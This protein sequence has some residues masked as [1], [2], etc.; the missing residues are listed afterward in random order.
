MSYSVH[1]E[2]SEEEKISLSSGIYKQSPLGFRIGPSPR[3]VRTNIKIT[4]SSNSNW[5]SLNEQLS[6]N[7]RVLS[8][9]TIKL[10]NMIEKYSIF[11]THSYLPAIDS[12][13]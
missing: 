10:N 13:E 9:S 2:D 1:D 8:H 4:S 5:Q 12:G 6:E 11:M 3:T 7:L